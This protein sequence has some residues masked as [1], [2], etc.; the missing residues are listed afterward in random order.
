VGVARRG[1]AGADIEELAD[2]RV[3]GQEA[4]ARWT[5]KPKPKPAV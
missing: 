1:Q 2:S 4:Y 5:A 3:G